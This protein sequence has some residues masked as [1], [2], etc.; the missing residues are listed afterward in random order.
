LITFF[1]ETD[2]GIGE[3]KANPHWVDQEANH[4]SLLFGYF[5]LQVL[6][7]LFGL[8]SKVLGFNFLVS[9]FIRLNL[10]SY[11]WRR[12]WEEL[13]LELKSGN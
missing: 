4:L 3:Q 1:P 10:S 11:N 2:S 5:V 9:S 12:L 6:G 7:N 13:S 8:T